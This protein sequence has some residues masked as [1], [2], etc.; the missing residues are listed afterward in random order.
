MILTAQEDAAV[1]T[2][3]VAEGAPIQVSLLC[4]R[5]LCPPIE[6]VTTEG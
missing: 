3:A 6:D 5:H 1:V 2:Q 4:V